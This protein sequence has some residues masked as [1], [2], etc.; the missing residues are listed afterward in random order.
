MKTIA[1]TGV[2]GYSGRYIAQEARRRGWRVV[3]LTNSAG[4]LGNPEG[5]ELR[6]MPW[7]TKE[8]VL[9]GVDVLIN[10]Y[11]V[12]FSYGGGK[13]AA[14]SHEEAVRNTHSLF[15]AAQ[16]AGVGR[17]IHTSITCPDA[18]SAL[19]YFRG[20]AELEAALEASG[21]PHS[22]LRPAVLFGDSAQESI[23]INNM[24]WSLRHLPAVAT[25]GWGNYELQPLHVQDF[26]EAAL[27]EAEQTAQHRIIH[28]TGTER[29]SF[30]ELWKLLAH[31]MGIRRFIL[32]VPGSIGYAATS[33][34]GY[35]M[36]DIMLTRDEIRGLCENRLAVPGSGIGIRPL[37]QWV[38]RH[39]DALG[40][41]YESELARR[42]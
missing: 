24:A 10:T 13:H 15:A 22:I 12:R 42:R 6:P 26:A 29:Y 19:P 30:R 9:A 35:F 16:Q 38:N 2:L 32:P 21:L 7:S 20:K 3:G 1:I 25:F 27:D 18:T 39:A 28:A 36:N 37:S 5:W 14:F 8:C 4:R 17:T 41:T 11:W 33:V 34:L 31:A 23:L 40:R